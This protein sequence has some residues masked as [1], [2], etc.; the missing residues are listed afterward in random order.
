MNQ[1]RK[2]IRQEENES[3]IIKYQIMRMNYIVENANEW[4]MNHYARNI[5]QVKWI[6]ILNI[7]AIYN[8]SMTYNFQLL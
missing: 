1:I 6:K 2:N 4:K 7:S 8:D 5:I 3:L